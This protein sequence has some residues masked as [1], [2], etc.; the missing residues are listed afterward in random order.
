MQKKLNKIPIV[1]TGGH[2]AT[3]A[4]ATI[5]EMLR[6]KEEV[7]DIYWIGTKHAIEGKKIPT[8]ESQ[9]FPNMGISFRPI[10]AGRLQRKF[11]LWT[12]PSL[13][14]IPFGFFHA[15][16]LLLKIRPRLI[17]SFG[18][19]AAFPVVLIGWLLRIPVIIHEQTAVLGMANKF[20]SFFATKI[21]LSREASKD[22]FP[23][24][25]VVLVGNPIMT[26][27]AEIQP[28]L[29]LG[30]PPTIFITGGSRGSTYVNSL[31]E[32]LIESLLKEHVV[33]HHTGHI[34][35]E[36]FSEIKRKLPDDISNNYEVYQM[37][38]PM[39]IDGV[40]KR[41]DLVISRAGANT[42]SEIIA[43]KRPSIL[44]PIPWSYKDE[45]TKN[46]EFAKSWGIAEILEQ[47]GD[48]SSELLELIK[49]VF[50]N[51]DKIVNLVYKKK[52]PDIEASQKLIDLVE[53][54]IK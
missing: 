7:W 3:T 34:D 37:I 49:K 25:K 43:S 12:I 51:W 11:S 13:A 26:Q 24:K 4:I 44:I 20:S 36:K 32:E 39:Q 35:F 23:E 16:Y 22:Y 9:V 15:L 29:T 52:S 41:A 40:Y 18:G 33:I 6:R 48:K 42:V 5:E 54:N 30:S 38:D 31:I 2:A 28:K 17:L 27:I 46:A 14:K 45:Q 50:L 53:E 8:L 21:A 1:L 10:V 47:Y 19:F